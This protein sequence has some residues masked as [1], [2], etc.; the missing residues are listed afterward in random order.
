MSVHGNQGCEY[1]Y[2]NHVNGGAVNQ[3]GKGTCPFKVNG[4][5]GRFKVKIIDDDYK[6]AGDL[7]RKVMNDTQRKN[8]VEN[9]VGSLK[10]AKKEI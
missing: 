6:Q 4:E 5:A 7:Y 9:I 8:L 2:S 1:S 10:D 3:V